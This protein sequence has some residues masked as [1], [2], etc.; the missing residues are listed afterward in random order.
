MHKAPVIFW[1]I[2][3]IIIGIAIFLHKSIQ[4]NFPLSAD[5]ETE[6]WTVQARLS[7]DANR[8]NIKAT[9]DIPDITPG[10]TQLEEYYI[11]GKFGLNTHNHNDNKTANWAIRHAVG[12]QT[13]YYRTTVTKTQA[14]PKW[15]SV[16]EYPQAP[17]FAEPYSTAVE[18]IIEDVRSQSADTYTFTYELINQLKSSDAGENISLIRGLADSNQ[19]I[20]ELVIKLLS[21][22]HIPTRKIWVIALSDATNYAQPRV[23]IQAY[24]GDDWLTFDPSNGQSGIPANHLVWK[25]GDGP[26]F[27][28]DNGRNGDL[29]FSVTKS[30][31]ELLDVAK[32]NA[33]Q[34]GS[35]LSGLTLSALPIQSQNTYRLLL[36]VPL[37]AL[38]VVFM[39]T[40]IGVQ[41]FGTFMPILIAVAFRETQLFWGIILFTA[42]VFIGLL[43]R[44]YLE[45]LRLLLIPRLAVILITVVIL[46][47]AISLITSRLGI[48]RLLSVSLFPMVIL[49]MTIERMS[50]AWEENGA[51]AALFQ[52]LGSL[53][54]ASFGYLLMTSEHLSYLMFVFPELLLVI[55][56]ICLLMGRYTGYRLSELIRFKDIN[57][58]KR[59]SS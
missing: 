56:G 9:L 45:H 59:K 16:P 34:S 57:S 32:Q 12:R 44:F 54:V 38:L 48:D 30:Y 29:Q 43:I 31:I 11:S 58:I 39:R 26:F 3:F 42:I 20:A 47:L 55:L 52:G 49:A 50:I 53:V 5:Q 1:S 2:V 22:A 37:G 10:Y 17:Y 27:E 36:M 15:S 6:A 21:V 23:L 41:T 7:F 4:L 46:M 18:K 35:M 40:F 8:R 25:V 14:K 19:E 24:N 33:K 28:L 13:L 51:Q